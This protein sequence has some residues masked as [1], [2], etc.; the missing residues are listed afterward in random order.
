MARTPWR[1]DQTYVGKNRTA[2]WIKRSGMAMV[3]RRTKLSKRSE[4]RCWY[5][6]LLHLDVQ[7]LVV[8]SEEPRRLALVPTG[9]LEGPTDR[10][11]LGIRR[12]RLGDFPQ[13]GTDRRRLSAE[14]GLRCRR[15]RVDGENRE[16]RRLNLIR[17]EENGPAN[18]VSEFPHVPRPVVAQKDFGCRF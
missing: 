7:G 8:G 9:D 13:R 1:G 17:S 3:L 12:S 5:A 14:C 6:V 4:L 18:N 16:M 2:D 10:L 11:L 15:R